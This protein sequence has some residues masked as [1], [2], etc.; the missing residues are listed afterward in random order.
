[1]KAKILTLSIMMGMGCTTTNAN[2][3]SSEMPT[4]NMGTGELHIPKVE[5]LSGSGESI[6]VYQ[7]MMQQATDNPILDF[8]LKES[9]PIGTGLSH[10]HIARLF[11]DNLLGHG[12][13][14]V[15]DEIMAANATIHLVDSFTPD[16]G[17]GPEGIKNIVGLY[18]NTFPDLQISIHDVITSG[19]KV[20]SRFTIQGTQTGDLPNIPAT[21]IAV[22]VEGMD[23]YRIE[24]G[25]IAEFWHDADTL[26][27]MKQLGVFPEQAQSEPDT[28]TKNKGVVRGLLNE[29]SN[30]TASDFDQVASEIIAEDA[31]VHLLDSFTPEFG[32]G[33]QALKG[34][35]NWYHTILD[36]ISISV[37]DMIAEGDK[38]TARITFDA[39][40]VG[41]EGLPMPTTGIPGQMKS[42]Q[43]FRLAEGKIV[44]IWHH[45]DA[46]GLMK[47]IGV[48][49]EMTTTE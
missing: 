25:K 39:T 8:V 17:T 38:V 9:T 16:L 45:A 2:E 29:F 43:V 12:D 42:S 22:S 21:G 13:L 4:F 40:Y 6:G 23:I 41:G 32:T 33:P 5:V 49:P 37:D 18:R 30:Q 1:M 3:M 28:L 48:V 11:L 14:E 10:R 19:D 15:A 31:V 47:L 20:I 24:N 35:F 7:A 34:I 46:L 27:L 26:G 44:E 36:D